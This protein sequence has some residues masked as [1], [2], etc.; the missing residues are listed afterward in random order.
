MV[1]GAQCLHQS[2]VGCIFAALQKRKRLCCSHTAHRNGSVDYVYLINYTGCSLKSYFQ[3]LPL[4]DLAVELPWSKK[5]PASAYS[6]TRDTPVAFEAA[7]GRLRLFVDHL[8]LFEA[9]KLV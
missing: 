6:M 9:I 4:R 1:T 3:P 8:E 7:G 2:G 5:A